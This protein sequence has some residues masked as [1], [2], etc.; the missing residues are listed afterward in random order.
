LEADGLV[1]REVFA[2]VPPRLEYSLSERGRSLSPIIAALKAW[3]DANMD[4]FGR[5][6]GTAVRPEPTAGVVAPI[7]G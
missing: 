7:L 2:Q 4:L 3:G 5:R 6:R 1:E